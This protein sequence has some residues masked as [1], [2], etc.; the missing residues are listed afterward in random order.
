MNFTKGTH[1][2]TKWDRHLKYEEQDEYDDDENDDGDGDVNAEGD[3][4]C[5]M[6]VIMKVI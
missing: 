3:V 1:S 2:F 6:M 5:V 4:Y